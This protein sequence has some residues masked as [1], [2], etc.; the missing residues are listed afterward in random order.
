[1]SGYYDVDPDLDEGNCACCGRDP[2]DCICPECTAC[3]V[4]GDSD[5]YSAHGMVFNQAQI[6]GQEAVRRHNEQD[7]VQAEAEA[8]HYRR[9]GT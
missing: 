7:M 4:V 3:G 1:M 9:H 5:C 8:E 6:E 2:T